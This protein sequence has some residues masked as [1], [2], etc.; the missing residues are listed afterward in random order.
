MVDINSRKP[1]FN[2]GLLAGELARAREH[3]DKGRKIGSITE[4]VSAPIDVVYR[5]RVVFDDG[6]SAIY[7]GFELARIPDLSPPTTDL[8]K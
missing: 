3:G 1:R 7:F 4:I 6:T 2:V 5:Y 8:P